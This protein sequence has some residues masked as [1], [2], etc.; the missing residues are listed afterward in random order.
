MR[1]GDVRW[2]PLVLRQAGLSIEGRGQHRTW[3]E[4]VGDRC[5]LQV[6]R[7]LARRVRHRPPSRLPIPPCFVPGSQ[8]LTLSR[9][10][11]EAVSS[12]TTPLTIPS[13]F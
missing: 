9:A 4:G 7:L 13:L 3:T 2:R 6:C 8:S 5:C 1:A 11:S 12:R 10:F